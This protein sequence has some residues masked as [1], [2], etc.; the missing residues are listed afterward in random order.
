[1]V[2]EFNESG[3]IAVKVEG[4][5]SGGEYIDLPDDTL[6]L[7]I[8]K[9]LANYERKMK[10]KKKKEEAEQSR[11]RQYRQFLGAADTSL[12]TGT[13]PRPP[14]SSDTTELESQYE[15]CMKEIA[16]KKASQAAEISQLVSNGP[17]ELPNNLREPEK[18]SLLRT[19]DNNTLRSDL[20]ALDDFTSHEVFIRQMINRAY[21]GTG[22]PNLDSMINIVCTDGRGP[23]LVSYRSERSLKWTLDSLRI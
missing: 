21:D 20:K 17:A 6:G 22:W 2:N 3:L 19:G 23:I 10:N 14:I 13:E 9:Q 15:Q 11:E 4:G 7:K 18:M 16:A 1:M 12:G 5:A 8:Y